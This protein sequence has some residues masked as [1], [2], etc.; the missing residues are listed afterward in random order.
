MATPKEQRDARQ[1]AINTGSVQRGPAEP[2]QQGRAV[3]PGSMA[4]PVFGATARERES[5]RR[6]SGDPSRPAD[7]DVPS[8]DEP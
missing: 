3:T 1:H 4:E 7:P 8:S 2:G 5:T 6:P